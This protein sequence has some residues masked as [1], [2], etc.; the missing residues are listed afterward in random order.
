MPLYCLMVT[1]QP[2]PGVETEYH[3]WYDQVHLAEVLRI[4]G[5]IHAQRFQVETTQLPGT[6]VH[7]QFLAIYTILSDDIDAT[8][9]RFD[10]ARNRMEGTSSLQ[11]ESVS[12]QLLRSITKS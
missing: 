1:T 6:R 10:Q 2:V 4:P 9:I 3:R 5:F 12:F 8:M 11:P 7:A